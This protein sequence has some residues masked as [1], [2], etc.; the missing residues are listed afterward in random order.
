MSSGSARRLQ[1]AVEPAEPVR[2][3]L[4]AAHAD[5]VEAGAAA[6]RSRSAGHEGVDVDDAPRARARR[7]V[8][9]R[10]V[11]GRRARPRRI[12]RRHS[13]AARTPARLGTAAMPVAVRATARR[14]RTACRP[15]AARGRT[16][17]TRGRGRAGGAAPRGRARGR[18]V[19]SANGS[20]A[21]SHAAVSTSSAEPLRRCAR[22]SRACRARCPCRSPRAITP[23]LQQVEREVAGAGAD[24]ERARERPGPRAEQ[25]ARPCRA[26]A[27]GRSRRTRCPTWRRS[28]SAATSW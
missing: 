26:P 3:Q 17:R 9:R 8:A 7:V 18:S 6:W 28:S 13:G 4:L 2:Q 23:V 20:S 24:L 25:L 21:A 5:V 10:A 12:A 16:R 15:A 14:R 22:A 27:R 11:A 1:R 19:S